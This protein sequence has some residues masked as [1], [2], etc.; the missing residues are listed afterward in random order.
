MF[1]HNLK[2]SFRN[3]LKNKSYSYLNMLGIALGIASSLLIYLWAESENSIDHQHLNSD[4]IFT[5]Y[6]RAIYD[7]GMDAN[8][9]TA[10]HLPGELKKTIPE[11]ELATG[12]ATSFRLSLK[13]VTKET[14]Q[15]GDV[16]LKMSGTRGS[17]DFFKIF[18]FPLLEGSAEVALKDLHNISISR[19]MADVFFGS[20]EKAIGQNIRYQNL[21]D[22]TV[23]AVFENIGD[24]S[25]LKFDYLINWDAWVATDPIKQSW[26]HFGTQTYI[27]LS[28]EANADETELKIKNFMDNYVDFGDSYRVELGLQ[29]FE[30][31]Y[32]Y[33][34]FENGKPSGSRIAYVKAFKG[35]A[36]FILVIAV[37]NF[38]N[39]ASATATR[40]A[41]EVGI[42]K[43]VGASRFLLGS[44]FMTESFLLTTIGTLLALVVVMVLLPAFNAVALK[45]LSFP[46]GE[47]K[48]WTKILLLIGF[49]GLASGLYPAFLL[50]RMETIPALKRL[51]QNGAKAGFVR[52]GLV[53]FQFALSIF[54]VVVTLAV[55]MQTNY[56]RSIRL[57]FEREN[58]IYIPLEGELLNNYSLFRIEA[59]RMPGIV[60]VD[61]SSQTP[62]DMGF[63]GSF[64]SWEGKDPNEQISF[65]PSSVGYDFART[66]GLEIVEGRDFSRDRPADAN[67]FLINETAARAIGSDGALDKTLSIFG[68]EGKVVG[69]FRDFHYSSLHSPIRPMILDVKEDLDFG[70]AVVR[71]EDGKIETALESLQKVS[72]SVNPGYAFSYTFVSDAYDD[73]YKV[74]STMS[75]LTQS[76]SVLA[77]FISCL[78]LFGLVAFA[79]ELRR[80]EIG[81]RKVL[82]ASVAGLFHLLSRQFIL[83]LLIAIAFAIPLSHLFISDWLE[84]FAY[85]IEVEWWLF[86]SACLISLLIS[87]AVIASRVSK[88]ALSNPVESLRSE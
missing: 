39:L 74:E 53:V 24:D 8:K 55:S 67:N 80:K 85:R 19:K 52:K 1:K 68:K 10:A 60:S 47:W 64:V 69:I 79:T 77:I 14:F 84:G 46:F 35:V 25:S 75:S 86:A 11:I 5:V 50:S 38:V 66:M 16:I 22:L 27:R 59:S 33:G 32:L 83:L 49:V 82:G 41:R 76:F 34:N 2:I 36:I 73:L 70:T 72:E 45:T 3:I 9:N 63:S 87:S 20:P 15:V 44:Q 37:I 43:V 58:L 4:R 23:T 12:Y 26:S 62:H 56:V 6:S 21:K 61:R 78:G 7:G 54:L 57:G 88:A 31:Q 48:F 28:K 17:P 51:N 29:K 30:D 81:I 42:R 13:G 71:I 65:T 40:K 18:N